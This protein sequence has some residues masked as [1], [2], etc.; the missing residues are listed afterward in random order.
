MSVTCET[1]SPWIPVAMG[2]LPK[3]GLIDIRYKCLSPSFEVQA[4]AVPWGA[5]GLHEVV[6]WRH[7]IAAP[8]KVERVWQPWK[9][10]IGLRD[11]LK[12]AGV[13]MADA[14]EASPLT[15]E[16]IKAITAA[17][18]APGAHQQERLDLLFTILGHT[19][20]APPVGE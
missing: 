5:R 16:I 7:H 18:A 1:T 19:W 4:A 8:L 6:A 20:R 2:C 11:G 10:L 15:I 12:R 3:N 13:V 14:D 17:Y 9:P